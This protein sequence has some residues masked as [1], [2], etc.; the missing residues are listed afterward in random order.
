[1]SPPPAQ[2]KIYH[3]THGKNLA[4]IVAKGCLWSDA[5]M[6]GRG[7]PEAMIGM[8]HIKKRRLEELAVACHPETKVGQF[9]PFYFCPRS[10][11]LF[12]LHKGN[13]VDLA[14]KEG[15]RPILHLEADLNE[16]IAWAKSQGR[17]WAFTDRNAGS[18]YFQSFRDVARLDQ[19]NWDHIANTDFREPEVKDAKQSEFLVYESFPWRL[20]RAIGVISEKVA[21]RVQ[22][23]VSVSGHRP[24]VRVQTGWYY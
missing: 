11:M 21:E 6:I 4:N 20:V 2:P 5:E 12:I 14:Y 3:I 1:M 10:V 16:A 24:D 8:S 9:V 7:G 17:P 23:I 15:Q 19:L 13:V 22:E 18:G